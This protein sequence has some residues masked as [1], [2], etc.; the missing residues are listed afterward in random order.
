MTLEPLQHDR[1][2]VVGRKAELGAL[3]EALTPAGPDVTAL[4]GV[5]GIGKSAL[6]RAFV[7]E[8][9]AR[10]ADVHRLDC[11]TIEPTEASFA[12]ALVEAGVE[13]EP[14]TVLCLDHYDHFLL[15]DAWLRRR[16]LAAGGRGFR[17][18]LAA[19][20]EPPV[21]WLTSGLRTRT[22]KLQALD[23]AA[24][25]ALLQGAGVEAARAARIQAFAKGHPLALQL[26]LA[27]ADEPPGDLEA[28]SPELVH[29]LTRYFLQQVEDAELREAL[30]AA[31]TVRRVTRPILASLTGRA[32]GERL[33]ERLARLPRG[34]RS[35]PTAAASEPVTCGAT[36]PT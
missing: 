25:L 5:P 30:E 32:T 27:G 18:V 29:R 14:A 6:L 34:T 13:L 10:G 9:R 17:L 1:A 8:G 11:R 21:A 35:K 23:E 7:V 16:L 15:L 19:R 4:I 12:A 28:A 3:G 36:P 26:A 2:S 24:S 22:I 33:Y 31:A 20:S